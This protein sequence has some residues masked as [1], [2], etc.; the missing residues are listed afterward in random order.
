MVMTMTIVTARAHISVI[1]LEK[2]VEGTA[3]DQGPALSSSSSLLAFCDAPSEI[4]NAF[5]PRLEEQRAT[6]RS[7]G[8]NEIVLVACRRD[9]Q[10]CS[11]KMASAIAKQCD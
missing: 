10:G 1:L 11:L 3:R 9:R 4:I 5:I 7:A 6:E 2:A 8:V